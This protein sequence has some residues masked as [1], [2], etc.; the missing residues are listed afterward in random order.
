MAQGFGLLLVALLSTPT[1]A[2]AE[3]DSQE[4][5]PAPASPLEAALAEAAAFITQP[6]LWGGQE[7]GFEHRLEGVRNGVAR[8]TGGAGTM[9]IYSRFLQVLEGDPRFTEVAMGT[10][11][12]T[13]WGWTF[14][15]TT[16]FTPGD[17]RWAAQETLAGLLEEAAPLGITVEDLD[18]PRHWQD[19][20]SEVQVLVV[21]PDADAEPALRRA[22][23][24]REPPLAVSLARWQRDAEGDPA[25]KYLSVR[26]VGHS[27]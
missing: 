6:I 16:R 5:A 7:V 4:P 3:V 2:P 12:R 27:R 1:T 10:S 14:E 26:Q 17:G 24:E 22:L 13:R 18:V 23:R 20:Q 15:L 19:D 11:E 9:T 8:I 25:R 21:L